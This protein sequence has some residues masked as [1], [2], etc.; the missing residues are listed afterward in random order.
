MPW[1]HI[2]TAP[3]GD[4]RLLLFVPVLGFERNV[5]VTGFRFWTRDIR[6]V[7]I[8]YWKASTGAAITPTHWAYSSAL[9]LPQASREELVTR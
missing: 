4:E 7:P 1:N 2:D 5:V 6:G 3:P 9:P 8:F